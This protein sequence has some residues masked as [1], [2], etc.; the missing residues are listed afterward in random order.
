MQP[1]EKKFDVDK[2]AIQIE[3]NYYN[4]NM[5]TVKK[6]L[7]DFKRVHKINDPFWFNRQ[8]THLRNK[9]P[10]ELNY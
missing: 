4:K 1:N 7:T 6:L 3:Y 5:N 10:L 9:I 2:H 8:M